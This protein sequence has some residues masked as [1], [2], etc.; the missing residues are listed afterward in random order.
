M[1]R[2]RLCRPKGLRRGPWDAASG[3][4]NANR[5]TGARGA[6]GYADVSQDKTVSAKQPHKQ[7]WWVVGIVVGAHLDERKQQNRYRGPSNPDSKNYQERR[8]PLLGR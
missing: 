2:V 1:A 3:E 5:P 7:S 6:V 8:H 4:G